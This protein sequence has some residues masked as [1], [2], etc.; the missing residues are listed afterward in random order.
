M[1]DARKPEA[2]GTECQTSVLDHADEVSLLDR[3]VHAIK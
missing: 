1:K 2:V 3:N